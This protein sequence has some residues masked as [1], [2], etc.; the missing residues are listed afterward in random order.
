MTEVVDLHARQSGSAADELWAVMAQFGRERRVAEV[1]ASRAMAA[2][3]RDWRE[4]EVRAYAGL[5]WGNRRPM[6]NYSVVPVRRSDLPRRWTPLPA[7]GF[8]QGQFIE[9]RPAPSPA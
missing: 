3:D 6:P 8:L 5:L 2:A 9:H 7:L 4:R 1:F